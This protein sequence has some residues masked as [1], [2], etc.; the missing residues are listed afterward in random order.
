MRSILPAAII[1]IVALAGCASPGAAAESSTPPATDEA[2]APEPA[3]SPVPTASDPSAPPT[4]NASAD[5]PY[6]LDGSVLG[7]YSAEDLPGD[8]PLIVWAND[9]H[10]LVHVIGAGSGTPA[11]R[12]TGESAEVDDG[13]LEIDFSWQE[14]DEL[15]ACTADLRVFGWAFPVTGAGEAIT[16]ATVGDWT[17]DADDIAVEVASPIGA[18]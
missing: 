8:E 4:P 12:P 18:D 13:R 14:P 6:L 3:N 5:A 17:R 1:G 15:Q 7:R 16:E 11:C 10:T 2:A 9:D